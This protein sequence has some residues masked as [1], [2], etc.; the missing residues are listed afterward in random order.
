[1]TRFNAANGG[2]LE[3]RVSIR[4]D[5]DRFA[6]LEE[7]ARKEGFNVSLIVRHLVCRFIED[8]RRYAVGGPQL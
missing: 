4:L 6:F 8:K 5:A 3:K 1:M 2:L 7:Y